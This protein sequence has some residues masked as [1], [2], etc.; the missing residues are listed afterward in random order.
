MLAYVHRTFEIDSLT[1][2]T[3]RIMPYGITVGSLTII[4]LIWMSVLMAGKNLIPQPIMALSFI[5]FAL[6]L[7][8]LIG[9]SIQLFGAGNVS[10]NCQ[11]YVTG[12]PVMGQYVNTLAWLEQ[13]SICQS[14]YSSFAFWIVGVVWWVWLFVM[15]IIVQGASVDSERQ[16]TDNV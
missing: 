11:T 15:A 4:Y 10:K 12:A 1:L 6:Y 7:A 2:I 14:W 8:G 9:T 3:H 13:N 16:F 5:F